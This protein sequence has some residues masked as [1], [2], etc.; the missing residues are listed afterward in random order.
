MK[1]SIHYAKGKLPKHECFKLG[2]GWLSVEASWDD[3]FDLIT[4][5]G[6]ATCAELLSDRR[7]ASQFKSSEL[8]MVDIDNDPTKSK[9]LMTFEDLANDPFFQEYGAGFYTTPSHKDSNPYPRYRILF[10]PQTPITSADDMTAFYSGLLHIYEG[11]DTQCMD[12]TRLFF[13]SPN[14]AYK[15]KTDR[16]IDDDMA[17]R[18]IEIGKVHRENF[19]V[20]QYTEEYKVM[21]DYKKRR[22]IECLRSI[23]PLPTRDIWMRIGFGLRSGG[24]SLQDFMYATN[25]GDLEESTKVWK[26]TR[27]QGVA[28]SMGTVI[29]YLRQRLGS[30]CL[31]PNFKNEDKVSKVISHL[32][33]KMI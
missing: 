2:S 31:V 10:R 27:S 22:I 15:F 7:D 8:V 17:R 23:S 11:A 21:D 4:I 16:L 9:R 20:S 18:V 33:E 6:H 29:H 12:P 3:L 13:G 30:D 28:C 32:K 1:F 5:H 19:V 25:E 14:A 26:S 24:M